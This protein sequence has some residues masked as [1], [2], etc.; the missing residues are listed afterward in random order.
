MT[1]Y[2][3]IYKIISISVIIILI[4]AIVPFVYEDIKTL[5]SPPAVTTIMKTESLPSFRDKA[6]EKATTEIPEDKISF[7]T[8]RE[9]ALKKLLNK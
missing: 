7:P 3:K 5:L 2:F 6:L 8:F 9:D 1:A 4:G